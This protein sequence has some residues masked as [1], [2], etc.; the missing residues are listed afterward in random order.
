M[1]LTINHTTEYAYGTPVSYALQRLRLTPPTTVGQT[2]LSWSTEVDGANRQVGYD[3]QFGNHVELVSIEGE[4]EAIRIIAKGEVETEDRSGV[5]GAHQSFVPLWLFL[6]DTPQTKRTKPIRDLAKSMSGDSDLAVMHALMA[7]VH[8]LIAFVPGETASATTADEA[9]EKRKGVCQD[10]AHVMIAAA[11]ALSIPARYVSGYLLTE[12]GTA[13]PASHAWAEMH[14]RGLGWVG[15]DAANKLCPDARYVRIA[16]GLDYKDAAPISGLVN[17]SANE[18]LT[19]SV[20]VSE[21]SQS[22]SQS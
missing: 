3:D 7:A 4:R 5:F 20:T 17:G 13:Q 6:R 22:Q 15:F 9:L 12:D 21:Q 8:E 14:L 11:R 10:H 19:V 1:R 18:T 2:V 16:T